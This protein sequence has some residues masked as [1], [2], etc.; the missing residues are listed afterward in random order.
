MRGADAH[1]AKLGDVGL[2]KNRQRKTADRVAVDLEQIILGDVGL[3][4]GQ[5]AIHQ[6]GR[7][8]GVLRQREDAAE[9]RFF[10]RANLPVLVGVHERADAGVGEHLGEQALVYAA[11]DEVHARDA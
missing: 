6:L 5:A 8:N 10:R 7:L 11:V 9:V 1:R 4:V 2:R 3:D